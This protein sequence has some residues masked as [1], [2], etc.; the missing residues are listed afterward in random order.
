MIIAGCCDYFSAMFSHGML[1]SDG[2]SLDMKDISFDG[3]C[4]L[5]DFAYTGILHVNMATVQ[6]V[7]GVA[8]FLQATPALNLLVEFFKS[9][10]TFENAKE[11]ISLGKNYGLMG[12]DN[13][14][15][16]MVLERFLEFT[17]TQQFLQLDADTLMDYL[18]QDALRTTTEIQLLKHVLKWYNSKRS[19]RE[20]VIH[21]VLDRIRYTIDGWPAINYANLQPVFQTNKRCKQIIK[22]CEEYMQH[23]RRKHLNQSYRTRVRF[24]RKTIIQF[25][26]IKSFRSDDVL[27]FLLPGSRNVEEDTCG[28]GLNKYFHRDLDKWLPLGING[29]TD[30]RSHN[31]MISVN[32]LGILI[33]GYLYSLDGDW[34]MQHCTHE[35]KLF[36]PGDFAIWDL[37]Y[38][39]DARAHHVAVHIPGRCHLIKTERLGG[40]ML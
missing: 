40:S 28:T 17:E 31:S 13:Y 2:S 15:R 16:N 32:D 27:G 5:L 19:E 21:S 39:L 20:P 11:L 34:T 1:E 38:M 25:G 26:G 4:C 22:R 36:T 23:A 6:D 24:D 35:V 7:L 10:M 3:L 29:N 30:C 14:H 12:L 8:A 9:K 33:G 18:E 37:P